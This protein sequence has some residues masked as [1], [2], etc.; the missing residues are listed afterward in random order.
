MHGSIQGGGNPRIGHAWVIRAT[1]EIY[2]PVL[3]AEY[4]VDAH[5]R[6]FNP[7][8]YVRYTQDE[9]ITIICKHQHWGPWDAAS[10]AV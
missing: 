7:M 2:D 4:T 6:I 9:V 8:E 10:F 1:G 5:N 3:D